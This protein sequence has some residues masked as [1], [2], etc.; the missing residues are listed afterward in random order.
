MNPATPVYRIVGT[1][2]SQVGWLV[3]DSVSHDANLLRVEAALEPLG[4]RLFML[5][6]SETCDF[7]RNLELDG[8]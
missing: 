1:D 7:V 6:I 8:L 5:S 3:F 4:L 2:D